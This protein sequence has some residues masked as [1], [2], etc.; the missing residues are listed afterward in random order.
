MLILGQLG[1]GQAYSA[2]S[3]TFAGLR[4][5]ADRARLLHGR[6]QISSRR[7]A[8][9]RWQGENRI[10]VD[11][12]IVSHTGVRRCLGRVSR[13]AYRQSDIALR[14]TTERRRADIA[15]RLGARSADRYIRIAGT[16]AETYADIGIPRGLIAEI[17]AGACAHVFVRR[18]CAADTHQKSK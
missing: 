7:Q 10:Q 2:R 13:A 9:N 11:V 15:C 5:T 8:S 6:W 3:D 16:V 18:Y 12:Y 14:P 4:L 1:N 17:G